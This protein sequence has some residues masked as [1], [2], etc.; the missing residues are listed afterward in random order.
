[1]PDETSIYRLLQQHLD[2]QAVGFPAAKSGADI[3]LLQHLFTPEEAG[4]A[5][6]LSYK[7]EPEPAIARRAAA[8]FTRDRAAELLESMFRKGAIGWKTKDGASHWHVLPLIVGMYEGQDGAP[9]AAFLAD[10]SA[11]LRTPGFR[12]AFAQVQPSQMRTVPIGKSIPVEHA[13]ATYDSIRGLVEASRGPFAVLPCICREA[14]AMKGRKCAQTSRRETCLALAG[15]AAAI[16]RRG[17]GREIDRDEV[18]SILDQNESDGLVLQPSNAQRPEFVCSCCG[19]CCGILF[20]QK[21][22]PHP[23][24]LWTS[25][26]RAAVRAEIC[27]RCGRC[28]SRCQVNAVALSGPEATASIDPGRCIGCGLCVPTCPSGAV[29]LARKEQAAVP[30]EDEEALYDAVKANRRGA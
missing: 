14:R 21:V 11:Y 27:V 22:L 3:R 23:A 6:H 12:A 15:T 2:R 10:A 18:M 24:D 7:P 5:L 9:G 8:E 19:C 20:F 25:S 17:H 29:H 1:V 28:V 13:A 16:L 26:Y 4:L 30:P